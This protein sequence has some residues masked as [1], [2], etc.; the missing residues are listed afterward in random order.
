MKGDNFYKKMLNEEKIREILGEI[1]SEMIVEN[2]N[3]VYDLIDDS[4]QVLNKTQTD[5]IN[6]GKEIYPNVKFPKYSMKE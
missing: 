4:I 1:N 3:E 6:A 2:T 5:L